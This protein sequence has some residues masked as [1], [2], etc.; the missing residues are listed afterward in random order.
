MARNSSIEAL[1]KKK[2]VE[3]FLESKR[4]KTPIV[5]APIPNED[6]ELCIFD[7]RDIE[8][9]DRLKCQHKKKPHRD[10]IL[11]LKTPIFG[12]LGRENRLFGEAFKDY[13]NGKIT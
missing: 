4:I 2:L 3:D 1:R 6:E 8:E 9:K 7:Y 5:Q 10:I 13:K 12:D 11:I